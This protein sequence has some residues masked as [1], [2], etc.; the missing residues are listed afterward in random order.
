MANFLDITPMPHS[1][2]DL[3]HSAN[4]Y[5]LIG[6]TQGGVQSKR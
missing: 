3:T 5:Y 4:C 2:S 1:K 6:A